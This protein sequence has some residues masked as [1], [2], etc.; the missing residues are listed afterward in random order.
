MTA[1]I[2]SFYTLIYF[3]ELACQLYTLSIF[4]TVHIHAAYAFKFR[5]LPPKWMFQEALCV[6]LS[7]TLCSVRRNVIKLPQSHGLQCDTF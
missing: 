7:T 2:Q 1:I 3:V 5:L 4:H 6:S